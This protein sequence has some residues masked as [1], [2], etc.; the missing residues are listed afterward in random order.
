MMAF[1][2]VHGA[3][4]AAIMTPA[5][6]LPRE[7]TFSSAYYGAIHHIV[8]RLLEEAILEDELAPLDTTYTADALLAAVD[9]SLYY[10]Q[11]HMGGYSSEQIL[12]GLRRIYIEGVAARAL[13]TTAR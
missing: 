12:Q 6:E 1:I 3:F 11:R 2:E 7:P 4:L 10:F 8:A 5:S 13:R 9:P